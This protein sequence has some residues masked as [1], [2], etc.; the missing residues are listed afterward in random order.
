M[1]KEAQDVDE[2]A[3]TIW[4]THVQRQV[5]RGA[6]LRLHVQLAAKPKRQDDKDARSLAA[7]RLQA[8]WVQRNALRLAQR[9]EQG[10][11]WTTLLPGLYFKDF[12]RAP[13]EVLPKLVSNAFKAPRPLDNR[14]EWMD[15]DDNATVTLQQLMAHMNKM[16]RQLDEVLT[17]VRPAAALGAKASIAIA[18]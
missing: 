10:S 17:A 2:M 9:V 8:R 5:E 1:L 14:L 7:L 15:F 6:I 16:Q 4:S 18:E 11:S 3:S 12:E 13:V